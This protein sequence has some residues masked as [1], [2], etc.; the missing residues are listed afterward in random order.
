RFYLVEIVELVEPQNT[1]V[2]ITFIKELSFIDQQLAANDLVARRGVAADIDA[3]DVVLL[4]FVKMQRKVDLF[5][6]VVDVKIRLGGEIDETILAVSIG[7]VLQGFAE[8]VHI[9][10]VAFLHG[11]ERLQRLDL[12]RQ[13]LVWIG[14]DDL[15]RS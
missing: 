7:I 12:Q 14:T 6:G 5:C 11:K 13:S 4:L 1:D 8:L 2:P 10:N 9:Q 15:E 3:T